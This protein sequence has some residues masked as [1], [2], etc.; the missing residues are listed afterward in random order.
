MTD[1]ACKYSWADWKSVTGRAKGADAT[2]SPDISSAAGVSYGYAHSIARN[3]RLEYNIGIGMLRTDYRHYHSRDNH[4]TLLWQENGEYT[5]LGPTK[6]K[7]S[8]V[9][10]ITGKNKK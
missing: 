3:L 5:W 1:T 2:Y 8:L 4:R 7:I 6:L 10:L 9:W